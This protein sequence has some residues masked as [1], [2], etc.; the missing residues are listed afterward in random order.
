M[1][2]KQDSILVLGGGKVCPFLGA[3][4]HDYFSWVFWFFV[5]LLIASGVQTYDLLRWTASPIPWSNQGVGWWKLVEG[6]TGQSWWRMVV[7]ILGISPCDNIYV[8]VSK[9]IVDFEIPKLTSRR[10]FIPKKWRDDEIWRA[11]NFRISRW[12]GKKTHHL[13]KILSVGILK[14]NRQ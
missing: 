10:F 2:V 3:L 1:M 12:V 7:D 8:V 4:R 13:D 11:H 14:H 6:E 5:G 9:I